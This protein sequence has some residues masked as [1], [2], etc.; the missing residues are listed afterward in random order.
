MP[1][2]HPVNSASG[3]ISRP[4]CLW[5]RH[6]DV[7][8]GD[9]SADCGGIME[10]LAIASRP[11]GESDPVDHWLSPLRVL[12]S[13]PYRGDDDP[14]APDGSRG[15]PIGPTLRSRSPRWFRCNQGGRNPSGRR[16]QAERNVDIFL[17]PR[18]NGERRQSNNTLQWT[19][20]LYDRTLP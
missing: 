1:R 15:T 3:T 14:I 9:R 6:L 7:E 11:D 16:W 13:Q 4:I 20:L 8:P 12:E 5:S 18:E 10:P 17:R 19:P 2:G